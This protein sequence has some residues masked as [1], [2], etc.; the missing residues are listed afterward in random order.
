MD[1]LLIIKAA[2][3]GVVEGLTEFLPV[4][5][6]GHL[7][8]ASDLLSFTGDF[9]NTFNIAIQAGA[10]LAVCVHFRARLASLVRRCLNEERRLA[11][12]L[13]WATVPAG[14]AGLTLHRAIEHYLFNVPAVAVALIA[15]GFIIFWVE[16]RQAGCVGVH[17]MDDITPWLAF[18]IGC[19]QCLALIPGTSR[20]GATIIGAMAL[21]VSRVAATQF[22]FFLAI[23]TIFAATAYSLFESFR[24]GG[25]LFTDGAFTLAFA[26]GFAVSFA[27]AALVVTWLLRY[28][29]TNSFN[30]FGLYRIVFGV[31]LLAYALAF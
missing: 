21:G 1:T 16:R 5:S 24:A 31:A 15:G 29:S 10:I 23:P 8:V 18:K 3:L 6:T 11:V 7:I 28:V 9:A 14:L 12:N 2:I 19:M 25:T 17:T 4:S 30:A 20:S 22:S 27:S 13:F 26:V